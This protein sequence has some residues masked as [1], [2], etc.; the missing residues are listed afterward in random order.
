MHIVDRCDKNQLTDAPEDPAFTAWLEPLLEEALNRLTPSSSKMQ[1]QPKPG[2]KKIEPQRR[3]YTTKKKPQAK[4]VQMEKPTALEQNT[5]HSALR[6]E[7]EGECV[8]TSGYDHAYS[9]IKK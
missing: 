5:M 7:Q 1:Q 8:E 6:G 9:K 4:S 3:F 2:T